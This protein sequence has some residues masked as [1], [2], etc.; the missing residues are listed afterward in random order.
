[1][2]KYVLVMHQKGDGCDYTI[3]CGTRVEVFVAPGRAAA[4][5]R[6]ERLVAELSHH[7]Q[8]IESATIYMID[9]TVTTCLDVSL[10]RAKTLAMQD[11][12][13]VEADERAEYAR[14]RRKYG[15]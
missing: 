6:G 10:I 7:E 2:Y 12:E 15:G 9:D 5:A 13:Q 11:A 8:T 14:L 3:G 4:I 1:M